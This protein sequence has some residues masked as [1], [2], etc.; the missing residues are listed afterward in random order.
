[1]QPTLSIPETLPSVVFCRAGVHCPAGDLG[2]WD[3][4]FSPISSAGLWISRHPEPA[5]RQPGQNK[6]SVD[7]A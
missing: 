1:M 4:L 2:R 7:F 5:L 3:G 6:S